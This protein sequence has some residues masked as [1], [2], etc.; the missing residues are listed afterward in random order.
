M[1]GIIPNSYPFMHPLS[2]RFANAVAIL[3]LATSVNAQPLV[4]SIGGFSF[5]HM[6]GIGWYGD[7]GNVQVMPTTGALKTERG[8]NGSEDGFRSRFRH[9]TEIAQA[10]TM[11]LR[12]MITKSTPK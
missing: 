9:E 8:V 11:P 7:W 12:L 3:L 4:D 10:G 5:T 1:T 6:S 2:S